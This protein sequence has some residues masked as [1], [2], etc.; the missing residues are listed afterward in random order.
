MGKGIGMSERVSEKV[1][2]RED[3]RAYESE[4]DVRMPEARAS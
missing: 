1:R 3:D 4:H 2:K